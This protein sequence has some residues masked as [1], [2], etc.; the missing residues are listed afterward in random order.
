M[1]RHAATAG[2]FAGDVRVV[3][4]GERQSCAEHIRAVHKQSCAERIRA[5]HTQSCA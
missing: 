5:V 4:N 1:A 3:N 2:H